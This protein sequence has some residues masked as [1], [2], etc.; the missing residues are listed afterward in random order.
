VVATN[1]GGPAEIIRH[2][3][4]GMLVPPK[5]PQ[6]LADAL[7]KLLADPLKRRSLAA[8]GLSRAEDFTLERH[9]DA[10]VSI[11]LTLIKEYQSKE[12]RFS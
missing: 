8:A 1:V 3:E 5:N 10:V 2:D 12:R 9:R 11:Y 6:A 4:N 7:A